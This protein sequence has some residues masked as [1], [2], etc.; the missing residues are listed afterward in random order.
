MLLSHHVV[1]H[2]QHIK[3]WALLQLFLVAKLST[4]DWNTVFKLGG[5]AGRASMLSKN[6]VNTLRSNVFSWPKPW[7]RKNL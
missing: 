2:P 7:L 1:S 3:Q 4:N 6:P 5:Y